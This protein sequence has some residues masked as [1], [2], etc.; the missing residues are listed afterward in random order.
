[1][2]K[3]IPERH[4]LSVFNSRNAVDDRK[5]SIYLLNPGILQ[6]GAFINLPGTSFSQ[7][8]PCD[9]AS[10]IAIKRI[11]ADKKNFNFSVNLMTIRFVFM[12]P[13]FNCLFQRGELIFFVKGSQPVFV[14]I[15]IISRS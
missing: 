3:K 5:Q 9:I 13:F 4:N 11:T 10:L 15:N 14:R 12:P 1:M 6:A 7:S 8:A 2:G